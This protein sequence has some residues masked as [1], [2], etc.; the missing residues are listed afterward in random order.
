MDHDQRVELEAILD[1]TER[2]IRVEDEIQ[3]Y[4]CDLIEEMSATLT[5]DRFIPVIAQGPSTLPEL[6]AC[7]VLL[8]GE[9]VDFVI[10]IIKKERHLP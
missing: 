4:A 8:P 9:M 2:E 3:E 6:T 7:I 10:S 5:N 1:K